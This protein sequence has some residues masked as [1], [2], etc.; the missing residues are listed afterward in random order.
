MNPSLVGCREKLRRAE[1]DLVELSE[2]VLPYETPLPF[3]V[4]FDPE[5]GATEGE[6]R[7]ILDAVPPE[8][9][10]SVPVQV[11]HIVHDLRCALDYLAHELTALSRKGRLD[12]SQW[13]IADTRSQL[14][15]SKRFKETLEHL[16]PKHKAFV[17]A[18]QPFDGGNPEFATLRDLS[19]RDKH[20]LLVAHVIQ[21]DLSDLK[22]VFNLLSADSGHGDS[23]N[24]WR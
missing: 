20:K 2:L 13:P 9:D 14:R 7:L 17:E 12:L 11:G 18:L 23:L 22:G 16:T 8:V 6:A 4:E 21:T 3:R 5:P 24:L 1:R 15:R 19:N 10:P